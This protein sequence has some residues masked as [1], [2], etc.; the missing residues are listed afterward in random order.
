MF[1]LVKIDFNFF[2]CYILHHKARYFNVLI[3]EKLHNVE[4]FVVH[5]LPLLIIEELDD[6]G[7]FVVHSLLLL[8]IEKLD[9]ISV[10]L[11]GQFLFLELLILVHANNKHLLSCGAL[12]LCLCDY[13]SQLLCRIVFL[14]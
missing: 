5:S 6:I 3:I 12:F 2:S 13:L 9:D 7:D 11:G 4:D 1:L 8:I 10:S 14:D